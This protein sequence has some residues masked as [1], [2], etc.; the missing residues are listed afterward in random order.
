[1]FDY[2][3]WYLLSSND[4]INRIIHENAIHFNTSPFVGHVTLRHSIN[5]V[6]EAIRIFEETLL[7]YPP[8]FTPKRM[9]K[10]FVTKTV[11]P[12]GTF[13]AYQQGIYS[14]D[15][16]NQENQHVSLAYSMDIDIIKNVFL[17][18]KIKPFISKYIA[19][20]DCHHINPSKWKLLKVK[21][22]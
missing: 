16:P 20:V 11:L 5:N 4:Q 1:M 7:R 18:Q 6:Q 22:I 8:I 21:H 13:Y 19:L 15:I 10:P 12:E 17:N 3:I 2:C 9:Y 14:P